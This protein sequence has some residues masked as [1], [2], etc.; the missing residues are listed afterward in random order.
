M[1]GR[2]CTHRVRNIIGHTFAKHW[3]GESGVDILC[4]Q[5]LVLAVEHQRGRF[6]AQQV[7]ER[8]PHHGETEHWAILW[9]D[10]MLNHHMG[11]E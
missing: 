4:V 11:S 7:G 6:A 8:A 2:G 3:G 1:N 9:V 10:S 5:V